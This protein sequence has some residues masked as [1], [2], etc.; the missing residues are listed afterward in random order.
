MQ[1]E[2]GPPVILSRT[3]S[4]TSLLARRQAPGV[5]FQKWRKSLKSEGNKENDPHVVSVY[6]PWSSTEEPRSRPGTRNLRPPAAWW[7]V[8]CGPR[9]ESAAAAS[10]SGGPD[11]RTIVPRMHHKVRGNS[12]WHSPRAPSRGLSTNLLN[13]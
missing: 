1:G 11:N 12:R 8:F 7:R 10:S 5:Q 9:R 13:K 6:K 3:R 2:P 4:S